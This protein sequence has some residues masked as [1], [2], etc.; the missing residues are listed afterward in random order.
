MSNTTRESY[1]EKFRDP[2]WQKVRLEILNRDGWSCKH[3]GDKDK[4]LQVHHLFYVWGNDPWDYPSWSLVTLCDECHKDET[5]IAKQEREF[6]MYTIAMAAS[7]DGSDYLAR[8]YLESLKMLVHEIIENSGSPTIEVL[9]AIEWLIR[10]G[11]K[12]LVES[13]WP[14]RRDWNNGRL[15]EVFPD[16]CFMSIGAKEMLPSTVLI[17][18]E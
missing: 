12:K 18:G 17:G 6:L 3:C 5:E 15:R 14:F 9:R 7:K 4:N 13:L 11:G 8:H 10:R 2:R 1:G 16:G